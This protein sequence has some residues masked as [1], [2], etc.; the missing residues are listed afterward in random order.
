[1]EMT[2]FT[3]PFGISS[4]TRNLPAMNGEPFIVSRAGGARLFDSKGTAYVDYA[5]GMGADF[6]GHAHPA[7]VEACIRALQNGSMPGFR[8]EGEELAGRTLARIG[9]ERITR[10]TFTTTGSEAVHL[11]CRLAQ[12]ITGRPLV[13][14]SVGGYDGWFD[15]LLFGLVDSPEAERSAQRPVRNGVTLMRINDSED[16]ELLFQQHG[17][18]LAALIVEPILGTAGSL[19]PNR[20]YLQRLTELAQRNGTLVIADE[21]L[22]G[23]RL[24]YKLVSEVLG[25]V[26]DLVTMGKAIGS[27]LPVAALLGTAKA[28]EPFDQNRL[29]RLGTYHGNPLVTAAVSATAQVLS[30]ADYSKLFAYGAELRRSI[31]A[32]FAEHGIAVSTSGVDSLFSLWFAAQPPQTYDEA[33]AAVRRDASR[34]IFEILRR[35]HVITLPSPWSRLFISF[36][37]G[38]QEMK[39]T[40]DAYRAAAQQ[41]AQGQLRSL[42][43]AEG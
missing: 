13:A 26:P 27:G 28:F 25:L 40:Q 1:M 29:P 11:A 10:V 24:G 3:I 12:H 30:T 7:V 21:V 42:V 6:L 15:S 43:A 41:L 9:G 17:R 38:A 23:L 33:K 37:H 16:L 5:L 22:V 8:H 4:Y 39:I 14:K 32:A 34:E 19:V 18:N 31:V 36:A 20:A 2:A 35:H